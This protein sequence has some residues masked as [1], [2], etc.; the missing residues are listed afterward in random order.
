MARGSRVTAVS[1]PSVSGLCN[2]PVRAVR[3][4]RACYPGFSIVEL[5]MIIG[6]CAVLLALA[7]PSLVR[8]RQ[9]ASDVTDL[10][11][12]RQLSALVIAYSNDAKDLPPQIFPPVFVNKQLNIPPLQVRYR[13]VELTGSWFTNCVMFH[14]AFDVL[15]SPAAV[16]AAGAP[17]KMFKA[18]TD[19]GTTAMF[20]E[21][22]LSNVF[23]GDPEFWTRDRQRGPTQWR[24]QPLSSVAF[25][26][27]KGFLWQTKVYTI[28][29]HPEGLYGCCPANIP[30]AVAWA[31]MSATPQVIADLMWG[32]PNAWTYGSVGAIAPDAKGPP[33]DGTE[34]GILGRDR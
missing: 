12:I 28:P 29:G 10:A 23:Y 2:R 33:I 13:G 30:T 26:S 31:D 5:L 16:R 3:F 15:P 17:A 11:R 32:V 21:F 34:F 24:A 18:H 20:S 4:W 25:P 14:L 27:A 7:I 22:Q 6:T 1:V 8:A 19:V 9:R